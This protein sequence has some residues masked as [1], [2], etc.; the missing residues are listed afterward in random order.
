MHLH[1]LD[2]LRHQVEPRDVVTFDQRTTTIR[3]QILSAIRDYG[4]VTASLQASIYS[5]Y[6]HPRSLMEITFKQA[7]TYYTAKLGH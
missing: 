3:Q 5:V 6:N 2:D 1:A 7:Q 4:M